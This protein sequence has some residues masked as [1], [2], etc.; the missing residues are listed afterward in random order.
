MFLVVKIWIFP[1]LTLNDCF[2]DNFYV[3]IT[4]STSVKKNATLLRPYNIE[5]S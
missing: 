2:G 4:Q 3:K 1:Q 5:V